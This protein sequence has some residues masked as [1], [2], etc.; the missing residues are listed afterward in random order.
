MH[1]KVAA[2][3]VHCALGRGSVE[4]GLAHFNEA[5]RAELGDYVQRLPGGER[6]TKT[7]GRIDLI[8]RSPF[9]SRVAGRIF[10]YGEQLSFKTLVRCAWPVGWDSLGND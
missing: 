3:V 2:D 9:V 5:W 8:F 6:E 1:L 7:R 10:L 4:D